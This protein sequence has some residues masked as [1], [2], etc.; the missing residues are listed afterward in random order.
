MR[1]EE[2][3]R[4]QAEVS[5]AEGVSFIRPARKKVPIVQALL[6]E[7]RS[8]ASLGVGLWCTFLRNREEDDVTFALG[9]DS[10]DSDWWRE[11]RRGVRAYREKR[12]LFPLPSIW[13]QGLHEKLGDLSLFEILHDQDLVKQV[14]VGCWSELAVCFC[15]RLH[16]ETGV[17]G[18][19]SPSKPQ[20]CLLESVQRNVSQLLVDDEQLV[21]EEKDILEDFNKRLISYSGEEVPKAEPLSV[22]RA[23]GALPPEGHG[24][25]I[26]RCVDFV[27]GKTKWFLS[28]PRSCL[29][30]DVGQ[31]LPKLQSRVHVQQGEELALARL[32]V[33]QNI[34]CWV[35]EERVLRYRGEM[36]LNGLFGIP[37]SKVLSNG[38]TAQRCI[39]NLIPSNSVL[40]N[41]P[42]RVHRLPDICQ[43]L[44]VILDRGEEVRLCQSDMVS[45]FY[46]FALPREW[47]ELLCFN[48][49]ATGLE[50]GRPPEEHHCKFYLGCQVLP[51]GW[52]SAVGVM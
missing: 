35:P 5:I 20:V 44:H 52:S 32:L 24:G 19:G 51:M 43:W 4:E 41:I 46:L 31:K 48:L 17:L 34:R 1:P 39:M 12:A 26:R 15:N 11:L 47:S 9:T 25:C 33:G 38:Q 7:C 21:W 49:W 10:T 37:K 30:D 50:L 18:A 2:E 8:L 22:Y 23:A 36:V 40:R 6:H 27:K 28:H 3:P 13:G 42:G 14:S 45:A 16:G 29:L